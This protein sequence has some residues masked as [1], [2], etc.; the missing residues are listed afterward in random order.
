MA[1][2]KDLSV[3]AEAEI[4]T[5]GW[6]WVALASNKETLAYN[7]LSQMEVMRKLEQDPA[8]AKQ[9]LLFTGNGVFVNRLIFQNANLPSGTYRTK[10]WD[11]NTLVDIS[12]F[13]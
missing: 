5:Y 8:K 13:Q 12:I 9:Y 2:W 4:F 6:D 11:P 1:I 10:I 3:P 7:N